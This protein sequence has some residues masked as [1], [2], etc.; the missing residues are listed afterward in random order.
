MASKRCVVRGLMLLALFPAMVQ[1]ALWEDFAPGELASRALR[2]SEP[3]YYRALKVDRDTLAQRLATAPLEGISSQAATLRLPMPYGGSQEFVLEES[4]VLAPALAARFPEIRTYRVR[5]VTDPAVSGRLDMTP[6]GFHALLTTSA[7]TVFIDPDGSGG[8]RS[9]YKQDYAAAKGAEAPEHFCRLGELHAP[10]EEEASAPLPELVQRNLSGS[11]RRVYRLAVA[12]TGEYGRYFGSQSAAVS[13]IV[14]AINRV[15]QIYGRDLAIQLQI[16]HV[17]VYTYANS[18]PYTDPNNPSALLVQNQQT[19]NYRVGLDNYDIGHLFGLSGG[20]LAGLS[21]ACT[22][23]KA[24]GYTGYPS[25]VGDAFYIDFVAHEIGHQLSATHSFNGTSGNCAGLNR[26]ALTAVEPGSGTT[27]M[28]Y[29]GICGGEDL[30][31]HSDATFHAVSIQQI[32]GF[33]FSGTGSQCGTISSTGNN[34]P[35]SVD[36]G[37][38]VT[39]P[40][41]T[42]FVLTGTVGSD[43]DG[44]TLSYQWDE[45][46]VG[47]VGT[48]S[49]NFRQDLGNNPLFRS[50]VPKR[51]STRY[52]P[53]LSTLLAGGSEV[54]ETLPATARTLHFR[55]T[56]R[57]GKSGVADDDRAVTVAAAQ[58]PFQITGGVLNGAGTYAGGSSQTLSW[59]PAGTDGDCPTLAVTLLSLSSGQ[60][61][62][63]D[64]EDDSRLDLGTVS[65]SAGTASVTLPSTQIAHARVMLKCANNV[66]FALSHSDFAVTAGGSAVAGNCKPIDG[67][68]LEHGTLFVNAG[69]NY[70]VLSTGGGGGGG[71]LSWLPLLLGLAGLLRLRCGGRVADRG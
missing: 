43:P 52:F 62:Y 12:T 55:M 59:D 26:S 21:V 2:T 33:A 27:I 66:F 42:P 68:D 4:P 1:A 48:N 49:T 3:L 24:Q 6:A 18:D 51:E 70:A 53:R 63:C 40:L 71:G 16:S 47:T 57:D 30:Q 67:E 45:I 29:A 32:H 7:G 13:N 60:T 69:S 5:S 8:Y 39:I 11:V 46:D 35:A 61:T 17:L 14:T 41:G 65:N 34:L 64:A 36:A 10:G 22:P 58:G 31:S 44:D 50:F 19:L 38:D 23:N 28:A 54:G 15:N 9:Y 56:V 25:P 20:G 37:A